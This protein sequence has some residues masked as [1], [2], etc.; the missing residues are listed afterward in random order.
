MVRHA[1][2]GESLARE[3]VPGGDIGQ[4]GVEQL[5]CDHPIEL[6]LTAAEDGAEA[7]GSDFDKILHTRNHGRLH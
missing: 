1:A 6:H 4:I 2:H 3:T 5:N 7:P